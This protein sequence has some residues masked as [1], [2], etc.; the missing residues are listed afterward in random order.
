M[1]AI[2]NTE[3]IINYK[4][5]ARELMDSH[6]LDGWRLSMRDEVKRNGV[7]SHKKKTLAFNPK[8]NH[9]RTMELFINTVLHE[10]AH[11]LVGPNHGHDMVWKNKA[12]EIGCVVNDKAY[13]DYD[14]VVLEFEF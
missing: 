5:L 11:A 2:Y 3:I 13:P 7:C 8:I 1:A 12:R 14:N 6:D 9:K 10:I 4:R